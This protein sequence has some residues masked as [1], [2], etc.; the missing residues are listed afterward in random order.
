MP[1]NHMLAVVSSFLPALCFV[2]EWLKAFATRGIYIRKS[3]RKPLK[4]K[5]LLDRV[6][7]MLRSW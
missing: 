6:A 7:G 2:V 3:F 1:L 4:L 5:G